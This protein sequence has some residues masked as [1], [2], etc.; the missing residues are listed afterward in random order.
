MYLWL[1]HTILNTKF[2]LLLL[3]TV[4]VSIK[5]ILECSDIPFPS[6]EAISPG[7]SKS[8]HFWAGRRF[9]S[10]V[11]DHSYSPAQQMLQLH[12]DMEQSLPT[13]INT[14][15]GTELTMLHWFYFQ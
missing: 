13:D 12:T 9:M 8:Q 14:N 6:S 4:S 15:Q 7:C 5:D 2:C 11:A 1:K 10:A 3:W